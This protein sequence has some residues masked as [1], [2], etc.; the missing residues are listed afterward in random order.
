MTLRHI[1]INNADE[2]TNAITIIAMNEQTVLTVE[3]SAATDESDLGLNAVK[4]N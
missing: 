1:I 2:D 3:M 4:L